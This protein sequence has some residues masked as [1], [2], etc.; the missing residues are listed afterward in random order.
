MYL[1]FKARS[2]SGEW[3]KVV[4]ELEVNPS[5][6]SLVEQLAK[7]EARNRAATFYDKNLRMITP[8][9]CFDAA[10]EDGSNTIFVSYE[11]EAIVNEEMMVLVSRAL[12]TDS[13]R[14]RR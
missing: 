11:G 2:K 4:H 1:V 8:A 12:D 14:G 3:D 10:M 6:S 9:Q 7:K 5:D 13:K